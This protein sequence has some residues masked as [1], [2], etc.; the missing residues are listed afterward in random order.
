MNELKGKVAAIT[1]GGCG[2]GRALA[3]QLAPLGCHMA[4]IDIDQS[5]LDEVASTCAREG[6]SITT[7]LADVRDRDRMKAL[8]DEIAE[9]HGGVHILVNN[10]GVTA[11]GSFEEMSFEDLDWVLDVNLKG[12]INGCKF[13]L[14]HLRQQPEAHI[15]NM[16]SLLGIVSTCNQAAYCMSKHAVRGLSEVLAAELDGSPINVSVIHPGGVVSNFVTDSRSDDP[17]SKNEFADLM[18]QYSTKPDKVAA[19]IIRAIR[20]NKLRARVGPEAFVGDWLKRAF[21]ASGQRML[22]RLLKKSMP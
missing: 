14:P 7:H 4:L 5:R 2:I 8:A 18:A 13:F 22:A 6:L 16:S 15:V 11:W 21:P 9:A 10:A 3:E 1:G 12:V 19:T 17:D 20:K